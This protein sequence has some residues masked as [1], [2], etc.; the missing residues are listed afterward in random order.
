MATVANHPAGGRGLEREGGNGR[1]TAAELS[2]LRSVGCL[3]VVVAPERLHTAV[4]VIMSDY[5]GEK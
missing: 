3:S 1:E 2:A 4:A 5:N